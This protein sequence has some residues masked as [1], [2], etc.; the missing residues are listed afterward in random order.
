MKILQILKVNLIGL[1]MSL[2]VLL[3]GSWTLADGG[4]N[5][6]GGDPDAVEFLVILDRIC[7]WMET[8]SVV[9]IDSM[10]QCEAKSFIS[11]KANEKN[12]RDVYVELKDSLN[13]PGKAKIIFQSE[14]ILDGAGNPK[15]ALFDQLAKTI[16]LDRGL[17]HGFGLLHKYTLIAMELSGLLG[18]DIRYD[19]GSLVYSK[20]SLIKDDVK[21]VKTEVSK[22]SNPIEGT[23][24]SI[25]HFKDLSYGPCNLTLT[26]VGAD[27]V[28]DSNSQCFGNHPDNVYKCSGNICT[29][30]TFS[31]PDASCK[32]NHQLPTLEI[33]DSN[34]FVFK[35]VC[36]PYQNFTY[37]KT[38]K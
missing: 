11:S 19:I 37:K 17:W 9:A 23:Y 28:H 15:P 10:S 29:A 35:T 14:K 18:S 13:L 30:V 22:P 3:S 27:L 25:D 1:I 12:C 32:W 34:T 7:T 20:F 6:G 2:L 4:S 26:A 33:L 16:K 5:S 8:S 21:T 38:T 31:E 36:K 24:Q